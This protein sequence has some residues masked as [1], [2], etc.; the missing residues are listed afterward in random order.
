MRSCGRVN[1][2]PVAYVSV[3]VCFGAHALRLSGCYYEAFCNLRLTFTLVHR[4]FGPMFSGNGFCPPL[5]GGSLQD[6]LD[7]HATT[8]QSVIKSPTRH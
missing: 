2:G 1:E 6:L 3:S 8:A 7:V 5:N 4:K